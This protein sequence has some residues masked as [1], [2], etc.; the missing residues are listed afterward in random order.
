MDFKCDLCGYAFSSALLLY[1][2]WVPDIW[3]TFVPDK[4]DRIAEMTI[5]PKT[6]KPMGSTMTI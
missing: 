1:V 3:S 2:H 6:I 5:Y 4:I